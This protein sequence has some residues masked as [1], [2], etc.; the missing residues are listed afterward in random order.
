MT[1]RLIEASS[2]SRH[3]QP[4]PGVRESL[5]A[6]KKVGTKVVAC[7]ES[8]EFYSAKRLHA[9][10]LDSSIDVLFCN[11][12]H[13]V[14]SERP[15]DEFVERAPELKSTKIV[16]IERGLTKPDPMVLKNLL[17]A[18]C[19]VPGKSA[20]VGDSLSRDIVMARKAGVIDVHAKYGE[21]IRRSEFELLSRVSHWTNAD[22][23]RE[24]SASAEDRRIEPSITLQSGFPEIFNFIEFE[25]F[26]ASALPE[27]REMSTS[28]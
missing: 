17:D 5:A 11:E 1:E 18:M 20:Y 21:T 13:P 12:D 4:Y 14:P 26:G 16:H 8:M 19:A 27:A 2:V 25:Q 6:I 3:A 15:E 28:K 22:I 7:T 9:L 23:Q 24:N 10:G